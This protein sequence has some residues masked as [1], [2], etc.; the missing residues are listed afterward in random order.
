M[1]ALHDLD[2]DVLERLTAR[3]MVPSE[4]IEAS[5]EVPVSDSDVWSAIAAPGNLTNVHPFCRANDVD[6]WPGP[7]ARD[8]VRYFSGVHYQR[9]FLTWQEGVGYDIEVGSPPGKTAHARWRIEPVDAGRARFRLIVTSYLRSDV[10]PA[11]RRRYEDLIVK[12]AIPPYVDSV[13]RGVAH[14]VGT[15]TPV[16]R[17]Q[18]GSHEIYS[19]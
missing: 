9:D 2:D 3:R 16:T 15:G 18:F 10:D 6:A 5:C 17:N 19:P 4:A 11:R 12:R 8:H 13:V 7:D 14:F 1:A